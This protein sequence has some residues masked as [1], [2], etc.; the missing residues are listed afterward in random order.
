MV[1]RFRVYSALARSSSSSTSSRPWRELITTTRRHAA[2]RAQ[3]APSAAQQQLTRLHG[4][5]DELKGLLRERNAERAELRRQ[6]EEA[7]Q[8]APR[9][10]NKR[11]TQPGDADA[12]EAAYDVP[13]GR[14]VLVPRFP[15]GFDAVLGKLPRHIAADA[16]RIVGALASGEPASWRGVKQ[17]KDMPRPVL[18]AR[19]GIHH[20]LIFSADSGALEVTHLITRAEL[21]QTLQRLRG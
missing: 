1:A 9:S 11:R 19:I 3:A 12:L 2:S 15:T 6:L 18:M 8:E 21:E 10:E 20:R 5:V 13:L 16:M 4:K 17:A 7:A 14:A